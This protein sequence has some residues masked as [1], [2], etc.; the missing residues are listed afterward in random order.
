V[1]R[2]V[3]QLILV[4][5]CSLVVGC[6]SAPTLTPTP[7]PRP[8]PTVSA[9]STL[10]A[11]ATRTNTPTPTATPGIAWSQGAHLQITALQPVSPTVSVQE[12]QIID[13]G[14]CETKTDEP[15]IFPMVDYVPITVT[16]SVA[17]TALVSG[18]EIEVPIPAEL[19]A[20]LVSLVRD[21]HAREFD[22]IQANMQADPFVIPVGQVIT[23][24]LAWE[25]RLYQGTVN[26]QVL[27][28]NYHAGYTYSLLVPTR[29]GE[30]SERCGG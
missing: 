22:Q 9:T 18:T 3:A 23:F 28:I 10:T 12:K 19:H 5:L 30:R 17:E 25:E 14:H 27:G 6:S 21:A 26:F 4:S 16:V 1:Q 7:L 2:A 11:T 20:E 13:F 15:A 24:I 8:S 29:A